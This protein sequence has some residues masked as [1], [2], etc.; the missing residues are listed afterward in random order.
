[1]NQNEQNHDHLSSVKSK[2]ISINI[3]DFMDDLDIDESSFKP[4][5]KGLGFHQEVKQKQ[6][7]PASV[8]ATKLQHEPVKKNNEIGR[9]IAKSF[10]EKKSLKNTVAGTSASTPKGALAAFY[11]EASTNMVS[12]INEAEKVE[13][14]LLSKKEIAKKEDASMYAQFLAYIIDLALVASFTLAT[15][16]AL[17]AVSRIDYKIL[18]QL[19][20]TKDQ[21]IFG[22]SLFIIYYLLYFTILD[23]NASPGKSLM[24]IRLY[25][26]T[27]KT[28]STKHTFGRALITFLSIAALTLP[29]LLDFQGRLS[30][31]KVFKD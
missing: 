8:I 12:P 31:T 22:S 30:G 25:T 10:D 15:I 6:Y 13:T 4:V 20:S 7:T 1:M 27:G 23:L 19:I 5:T 11:G 9:S 2:A 28:V 18:L 26:V 21:A 17:V 29:T 24:G 14:T 16:A 3:P